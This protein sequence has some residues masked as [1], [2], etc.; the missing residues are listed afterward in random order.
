MGVMTAEITTL[1]LVRG[2]KRHTVEWSRV[3]WFTQGVP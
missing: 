3:I 1:R 2:S